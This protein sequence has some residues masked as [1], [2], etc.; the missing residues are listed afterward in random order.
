MNLYL[1]VEGRR[2]EPKIY[3][4]WIRHLVPQMQQINDPFQLNT[5]PAL[6]NTFY[7]FSGQGY[8]SLLC[9]H[10]ANAIEDVNQIPRIDHFFICLDSDD[11]TAGET[12]QIVNDFIAEHGLSLIHATLHII[13]QDCCIETWLLGNR[14]IYHRTPDD[15]GLLACN[16]HYDVQQNDP[17]LLR[18]VPPGYNCA[19]YHC[20]YLRQIFSARHTSYT[21]KNP[22]DAAKSTYLNELIS[23]H[24][25]TGHISSFG[26][27]KNLMLSLR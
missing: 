20:H 22:G 14:R 13:V 19:G 6:D 24:D 9:N 1:L 23:R 5:D 25:E 27:F 7:V 12:R 10:L 4:E 21:K 3:P 17:E 26:I 18:T 15:A 16:S 2:T 8:P 11:R